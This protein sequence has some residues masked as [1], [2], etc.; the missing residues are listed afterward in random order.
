MSATGRGPPLVIVSATW[1]Q[2]VTTEGCQRRKPSLSEGRVTRLASPRREQVP[3]QGHYWGEQKLKKAGQETVDGN[4]HLLSTYCLPGTMPGLGMFSH[5]V[6]LGNPFYRKRSCTH[7]EKTDPK[8][9]PGRA[10]IP[11][12]PGGKGVGIGSQEKFRNLSSL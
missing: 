1:Q 2:V 3:V 10:Q 5:L 4:Y 11:K 6:P 12:R 8:Q 7:K 9:E